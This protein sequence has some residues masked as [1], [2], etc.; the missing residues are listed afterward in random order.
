MA[1]D[2]LTADEVYRFGLA[3]SLNFADWTN[4]TAA[5]MNVNRTSPVPAALNFWLTCALNVDGTKFDLDESKKDE[6]LTFCQTAGTQSQLSRSA[7]VV[8]QIEEAKKRWTVATSVLA[9]DGYNTATLA[10]SL[11]GYRGVTFFAWMSVGKAENAAFVAGD[12]VSLVEVAT[13]VL[14]PTVASGAN[15]LWTQTFAKRSLIN[16]NYTLLA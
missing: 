9:A 16:W 4:P 6:S 3:S 7:T 2:R 5:E 10:K 8:Y 11:L 14:I 12:K 1:L 13:D 15:T